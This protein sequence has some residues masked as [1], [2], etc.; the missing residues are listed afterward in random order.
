MTLDIIVPHYDETWEDGKKLFDILALQRGVNFGEFRVIFVNDGEENNVYPKI[1]E[2]RYPYQTIGLTIPHGG[3][4]AARNRGID[5]SDA[6]WV[7]FCDF[8]DTFASVYALKGYFDVLGDEEHDV[9][10]SPFY[11]ED[12][13]GRTD[14]VREEFNLILTHAK[15]YR[16]SFLNERNIRFPAGIG[17]SEDTAFNSVVRMELDATWDR[18]GKIAGEIV[19]Y[20]YTWREG[21]ITTDP[22]KAYIR[23][24]DLYRRQ[25]WVADQ[26]LRRGWKER[27]DALVIRAMCDAWVALYRRELHT[28][29]EPFRQEAETFWTEKRK[30]ID[31]MTPAIVRTAVTGAIREAG[32]K[33][34]ANGHDIQEFMTWLDRFGK[35]RKEG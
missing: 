29:M 27:H 20:I 12:R 33:Q 35:D 16:R 26:Y 17:Y 13:D 10:W 14:R 30:E 7:M 32:L 25:C 18:F 28:D 11:T 19:P 4:S 23:A 15:V 8:D 2:Q 3:V 24:R 6:K 1:V 31:G 9:L 34:A 21:S 5:A 22:K